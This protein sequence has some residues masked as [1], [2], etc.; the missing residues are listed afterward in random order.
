MKAL[1]QSARHWGEALWHRLQPTLPVRAWKRYG[2]L[3][4]DRLA[5]AASF[6]G[7][8]S[9]F[10]LILLAASVA[11]RVSGTQ[12]I[13][14]VQEL[15]NDNFP[16]LGLNV[17]RFYQNA[18]AIG[19]I[20]AVFL[21]FAGLRWVD[22][23][24][25]AVRSMWGMDDQPGNVVVR[26]L[27]D[28]A[29]LVGLGLLLAASWATSVVVR[30]MAETVL[31]WLGIDGGG[32]AGLLEVFSWVV[33]VGVN[34]VL[35]AY[36]LAG[37]PRIAVPMRQQALTALF[38]ALVFEVLKTFLVEYVVGAGMANAYGAF[39]TPVVIILWIYVVTRLLM[40]LAAL[41][42]ESAID[43]LEAD[44]RSAGTG[45]D[46]SDG[47]R[48]GDGG[49]LVGGARHSGGRGAAGG[50]ELSPSAGQARAVGVAAGALL[51]VVGVGVIV[52]GRRAVRTVRA[53]MGGDPD[54]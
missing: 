29:A 10:P 17:G 28:L 39:A 14:T 41:T 23:V 12:G 9:L 38:G 47:S 15:V 26:K 50:V 32:A 8:S 36:L 34:A 5:G 33:S 42:A 51:G 40:V 48:S 22:S 31:D 11:S 53:V 13:A 6:Y 46:V 2:D 44:E 30:R 1:L 49:P 20:S 19:A 52:V 43:H 4:G 25:A 3:R 35:F 7:F 54:A 37:L 24:R 18:G 16:D 45:D 21:I 27:L